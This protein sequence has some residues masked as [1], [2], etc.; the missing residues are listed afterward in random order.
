MTTQIKNLNIFVHTS[1]TRRWALRTYYSPCVTVFAVVLFL[2]RF[3]L[4]VFPAYTW[5]PALQQY[6]TEYREGKGW[7]NKAEYTYFSKQKQPNGKKTYL[8]HQCLIGGATWYE[9]LWSVVRSLIIKNGSSDE[10]SP[11]PVHRPVSV[12]V[13]PSLGVPDRQVGAGCIQFHHTDTPSTCWYCYHGVVLWEE[14]ANTELYHN[15]SKS[16][17]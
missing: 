11:W 5:V 16:L 17:S 13:V 3:L 14:K 2:I 10:V 4:G 9:A 1:S 12:Q 7:R 15:K 8:Y 6:L